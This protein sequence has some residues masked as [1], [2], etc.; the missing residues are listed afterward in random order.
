M[1]AREEMASLAL[2]YDGVGVTKDKDGYLELIGPH[3]TEAMRAAMLTMSGC[4]LVVRG[5]W[6]MAGVE[7]AILDAPYRIGMAMADLVE[8]AKAAGAWR[9]YYNGFPGLGDAVLVGSESGGH[10]HVYTVTFEDAANA[11]NLGSVDGGQVDEYGAQIIRARMRT[12][13]NKNGRLWDTNDLG[14]TRVVLGWVDVE[15]LRA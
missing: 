11:N 6:R 13:E 4:A 5:L 12:V 7:S 15:A 1:G 14:L 8:I 2:A 10:E 3:E 9:P